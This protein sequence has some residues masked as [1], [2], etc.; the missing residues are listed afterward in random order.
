MLSKDR[1]TTLVHLQDAAAVLVNYVVA[2]ALLFDVANVRKGQTVLVHSIGECGRDSLDD[3]PSE[4]ASDRHCI[5]VNPKKKSHSE[6]L[7]AA[8]ATLRRELCSDSRPP[9]L[10]SGIELSKIIMRDDPCEAAD[11]LPSEHSVGY[12]PD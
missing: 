9:K 11:I 10:L 6:T 8:N 4:R 1:D 5:S 3:R 7:T 2:H 12:P